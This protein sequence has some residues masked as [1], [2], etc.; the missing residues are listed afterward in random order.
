M[1]IL[2]VFKH[3]KNA[4]V[5]PVLSS[6]PEFK[7]FPLL[8]ASL[9]LISSAVF[10][11]TRVVDYKEIPAKF[12]QYQDR[13]G[14][15]WQTNNEGSLTSGETQYLPSGM[16]L[17]VDGKAFAPGTAKLT[18]DAD[19]ALLD[20]TLSE[21]SEGTTI[22]RQYWFDL[23]RGGVRVID[24]IKNTGK[25]NNLKVELKTAFQFPW[26]NLVGTS[27]SILSGTSEVE[28]SPR[29]I[30]VTAKFSVADGRQDTIVVF[31]GENSALT[32]NVS[33]SSNSREL[34]MTY[35]LPIPPGESRS[36]V[37]WILRRNIGKLDEIEREVSAFYDRKQFSQPRVSEAVAKTV[38]NFPASAFPADSGPPRDLNRLVA[39][40]ELLSKTEIERSNQDILWISP[41]NQL[42]GSVSPKTVV[43]LDTAAIPIAKIAAI[44]GGGGKGKQPRV[45]FRDGTVGVGAL[46]INDFALKIG[47]KWAVENLD[48]AEINLLLMRFDPSDGVVPE[49]TVSFVE[50]R[51]GQVFAVT[52]VKPAIPLV[53]VWGRRTV[54]LEDLYELQYLSIPRP[55]YRMIHRDGS[56]LSVLPAR[57]DLEISTAGGSPATVDPRSIQRIWRN[58]LTPSPSELFE[59]RWLEMTDVPKGLMP[60]GGFLLQGNNLYAGSFAESGSITLTDGNSALDVAPS[61]IVSMRKLEPSLRSSLPQFEV[62][63]ADGNLIKGGLSQATLRI[64]SEKESW[65]VPVRHIIAYRTEGGVK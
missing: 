40:N 51:S 46:E 9:L 49:K 32:P 65:Q 48:T 4:R 13:K 30:G 2:R 23:K 64:G 50:L 38:A 53:S 21:K 11:E 44:E 36:L 47:D 25:S 16:K 6:I 12:E 19:Q 63:L 41:T 7:P 5:Y 54:P 57:G 20:L 56:S 28:I 26:Q 62:E 43:T 59:P 18:N 55:E 60:A 39:L 45:F 42:R 27:G 29:D 1:L 8:A 52:G 61:Q 58:G 24:T 14:F 34:V 33:A 22:D 15:L 3:R 37:H 17:F 10:A 31:R 35:N